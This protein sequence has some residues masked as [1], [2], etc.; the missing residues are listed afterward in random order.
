MAPYKEPN[1]SRIFEHLRERRFGFKEN[2]EKT[3][4]VEEISKCCGKRANWNFVFKSCDKCGKAFEPKEQ[5]NMKQLK[6]I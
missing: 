1:F 4:K 5:M 6:E 2:V 3:L